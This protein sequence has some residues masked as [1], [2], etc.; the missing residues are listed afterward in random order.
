MM[1]RGHGGDA[2]SGGDCTLHYIAS[3]L[4]AVSA[5]RC[6]NP[7]VFRE[8]SDKSLRDQHVRTAEAE[9]DGRSTGQGNTDLLCD[10]Q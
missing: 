6:G 5:A 10:N 2:A 8:Q 7:P 1:W 9:L 3:P 4:T